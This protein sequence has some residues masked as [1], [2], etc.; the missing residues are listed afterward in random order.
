MKIKKLFKDKVELFIFLISFFIALTFFLFQTRIFSW[1]F[2]VYVMNGEYFLNKSDYFEWLRPPL[3]PFIFMIFRIFSRKFA[4]YS[5]IIFSTILYFFS[6]KLFHDKFLKNIKNSWSFYLFAINPYILLRGVGIGTEL[7]SLSF[8]ILFVVFAFSA[9]SFIFLG[10]SMLTRYS[11]II[12]LPTILLSKNIK[13][14]LMALI[15]IFFVFL[16]WLLINYIFTGHA[17]TSIGDYYALNSL[18]QAP[19]KFD[20]N[21]L[22]FHLVL[23]ININFP[24]LILGI[25]NIS[26]ILKNEKKLIIT[27]ILISF[28]TLFIYM[29]TY[30]KQE[31]FLFNLSLLIFYLSV[32][33]FNFIEK[34]K[35]SNLTKVSIVILLLII[36]PLSSFIILDKFTT[37]I[38]KEE[39]IIKEIINKVDNC[40]IVSDLWVY[41]N[42]YGKK[43]IPPVF[44]SSY[45]I[46]SAVNEGYNII[47]FKNYEVFKKNK[48]EIENFKDYI[49]ENNEN[50]IWIRNYENCKIDDKIN[51]TYIEELKSLSEFP[52]DFSGC[53]ALMLKLKLRKICK[54]FNFL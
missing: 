31:R 39:K 34:T 7:V 51:K 24:F 11:N 9:S 21:L 42:W 18:E 41:F 36:S 13:K 3:V 12:L 16:P 23:T 19:P 35:K 50:Y 52:Q 27:L 32:H 20:L 38:V 15:I 45:K 26:K 2:S 5:F 48:D 29:I 53:D 22:F 54:I 33:G 14:I 1:D 46:N 40:T 25:L 8:I 6:L 28:L 17:L 10:L 47:L 30:L 4:I 49:I 43:A 44:G 37:H